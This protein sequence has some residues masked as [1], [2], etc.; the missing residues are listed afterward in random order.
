ENNKPIS[1]TPIFN[2]KPKLG[3]NETTIT[4]KVDKGVFKTTEK[5]VKLTA[6]TPELINGEYWLN[7][8][9]SEP[10]QIIRIFKERPEATENELVI[11]GEVN[12]EKFKNDG[13]SAVSAKGLD[14][15][16]YWAKF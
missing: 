9:L 1:V 2:D 14:N 7:L 6:N 13:I 4:G 16:K 5:Y 3:K 11:R 8:K 15:G 10:K 12:K